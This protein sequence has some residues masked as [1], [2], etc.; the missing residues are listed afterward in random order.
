[1]DADT[2][3]LR[4]GRMLAGAGVQANVTEN[5]YRIFY[6]ST[7]VA[8]NIV[9]QKE[10]VLVHLV[11]PLVLG[12][13]NTPELA[14]WVA[15]EGQQMYFGAASLRPQEGGL[16]DVFLEHTLLGDYL[17]EDELHTAIGAVLSTAND[18]DDELQQRF[19]GMRV[20]DL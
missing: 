18:W 5:G 14:Y 11:A 20:E 8:V 4:V 17:D 19:G 6:G 1:M 12:V 16:A 9:D 10:R 15:V 13:P 2:V 3:T 7:A